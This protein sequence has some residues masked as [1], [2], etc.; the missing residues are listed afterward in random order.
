MRN[1]LALFGLLVLLAVGVG[2]YMGWYK[3]SFTRNTDGNLE[4]KTN[5]DTKKVETDSTT[6][7]KNAATVV[8]SHIDKSAQ[9]PAPD[10]APGA[11]PGPVVPAQATTILPPLPPPT[12]GA[13]VPPP[14]PAF[15]D[16]TLVPLAPTGPAPAPIN[17]M[18]PK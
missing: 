13:S 11:T 10:G 7:F 16:P 1:L 8:G 17:L 12:Q 18:P 5:V 2:W 15:P 3:F 6:F 9:T 4:I 14:P